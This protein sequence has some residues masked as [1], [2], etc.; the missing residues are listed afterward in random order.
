MEAFRAEVE[1]R[2]RELRDRIVAGLQQLEGSAATFRRT[3]WERPGGGGGEMSEL[4]G[5]L[6]EETGC[7]FSAAHGDSFPPAPPRALPEG[8]GAHVQPPRFG[9]LAR[10]PLF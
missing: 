4:R 8:R 3:G 9:G 5:G 2:F 6:F 7:N 1:Q 10:H